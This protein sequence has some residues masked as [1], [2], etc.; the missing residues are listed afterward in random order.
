MYV[1]LRGKVLRSL[2]PSPHFS[3][4]S[5]YITQALYTPCDKNENIHNVFMWD[6]FVDQVECSYQHVGGQSRAS[7]AHDC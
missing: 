7:K 5:I 6:R 1:Y 2:M 3:H 4:E